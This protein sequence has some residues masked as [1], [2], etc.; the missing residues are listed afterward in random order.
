MS[1]KKNAQ[2]NH[3]KSNKI[4]HMYLSKANGNKTWAIKDEI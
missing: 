4:G 2:L 3:K 1:V